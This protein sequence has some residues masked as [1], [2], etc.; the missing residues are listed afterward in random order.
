MITTKLNISEV[1]F[2]HLRW[3][4]CK[5][6]AKTTFLCSASAVTVKPN[7][8]L[9]CQEPWWVS[10]VKNASV[11]ALNSSVFAAKSMCFYCSPRMPTVSVLSAKK[12]REEAE[13]LLKIKIYVAKTVINSDEGTLWQYITFGSNSEASFRGENFFVHNK[14]RKQIQ[15]IKAAK[16]ARDIKRH[17]RHHKAIRK[18]DHDGLIRLSVVLLLYLAANSIKRLVKKFRRKP[19]SKYL[20]IYIVKATSAG[21][22]RKLR[23]AAE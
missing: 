16:K 22:L 1:L 14:R 15:L 21:A 18:Q 4:W 2:L 17:L 5:M 6:A 12:G 9:W 10:K 19:G 20:F 23:C 13:R 7:C 3:W 11:I 8:V